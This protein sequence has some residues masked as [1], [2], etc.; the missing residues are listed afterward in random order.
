M[1]GGGMVQLRILNQL[2]T[3]KNVPLPRSVILTIILS[4]PSNSLK[5]DPKLWLGFESTEMIDV[6]NGI[7]E[8][9]PVVSGGAIDVNVGAKVDLVVPV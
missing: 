1:E 9:A 5:L 2:K 6:D 4:F 8:V 3:G 7:L